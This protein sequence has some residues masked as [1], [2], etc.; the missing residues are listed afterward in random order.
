MSDEL[1]PI[2]QRVIHDWRRDSHSIEKFQF[3]YHFLPHPQEKV[4][5]TLLSNKSMM[6]YCVAIIVVALIFRML[7]KLLPG[8]LGYASDINV[9]DLLEYTNQQRKESGLNT[10]VLNESLTKAAEN[11]ARDMFKNGYWA[12]VSPLGTEPWDFILGQDYDYVYAGENLAKNF[13][14]SKEV[15]GAWMDSPSHRENLLNKNY[16]EIGFAVVNGV[17]DGYETT[18]VVQMFGRPRNLDAM[19]TKDEEDR[20]LRQITDVAASDLAQ[21]PAAEVAFNPETPILTPQTQ[22]DQ[23]PR[24]L[25]IIDVSTAAK[26]I[27]FAFGGFVSLLLFLDIWYS[28]KMGILKFNGHTFAHLTLLLLVLVSIWFVLKPGAVL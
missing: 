1:I 15:V 4:R 23:G 27:S 20:I 10:L 8:V 12:H 14:N 21:A 17:M 19:A 18:L 9:R 25:P 5:A 16:D 3:M 11:K 13:S 22:F 7:P 6:M 26:G 2:K 24:V 28:R